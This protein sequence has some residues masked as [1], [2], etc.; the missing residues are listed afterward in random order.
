L[1]KVIDLYE[2]AKAAPTDEERFE[3]AMQIYELNMENLWIVGCVTATL[4]PVIVKN[5]FRNVPEQ[6][7][8]GTINGSPN[9]ANP[10]T[11][12]FKQS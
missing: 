2:Q 6:H 7:L 9:N 1:R 10:W 3:L 5:N 4:V 11:W 8:H 12:F